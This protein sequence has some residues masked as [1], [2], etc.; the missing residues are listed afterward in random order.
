MPIYEYRCERCG[1]EVEELVKDSDEA[2][3]CP[4]CGKQMT[5]KIS[6]S[7][8]VLKGGGWY[9]NENRKR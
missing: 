2:V 5:R 8:F 1:Y 4:K 3:Y 7:T 9:R 6:V